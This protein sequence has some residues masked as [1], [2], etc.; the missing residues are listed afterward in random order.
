MASQ[1]HAAGTRDKRGRRERK[2]RLDCRVKGY[3]L[4]TSSCVGLK[5]AKPGTHK[6][7]LTFKM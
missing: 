2:G 6:M 4:G 5:V 1:L 7:G 3:A